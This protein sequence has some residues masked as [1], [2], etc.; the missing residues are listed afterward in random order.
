M[1]LAFAK[2]EK[3]EERVAVCMNESGG[4]FAEETT[5]MVSDSTTSASHGVKEA[6]QHADRAGGSSRGDRCRCTGAAVRGAHV[7][8]DYQLPW[9]AL[10]IQALRP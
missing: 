7:V 2:S 1:S 5:G 6:P 9:L 10:P 4:N 3:P 8:A